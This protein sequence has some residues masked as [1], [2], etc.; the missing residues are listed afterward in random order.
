MMLKYGSFSSTTIFSLLQALRFDVFTVFQIPVIF[1][2]FKLLII[3]NIKDIVKTWIVNLGI[4]NFL[5]FL[6]ITSY[7][8]IVCLVSFIRHMINAHGD[9]I[10]PTVRILLQLMCIRVPDKAEYRN[11]VAGVCNIL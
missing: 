7:F 3:H 8:A 5:G 2:D 4:L 9:L 10:Y 11:K 1:N 6:Y